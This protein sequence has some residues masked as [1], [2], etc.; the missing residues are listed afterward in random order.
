MVYYN[1]NIVSIDIGKHGAG[2][3]CI[4]PFY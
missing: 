2:R 1:D 3:W 4:Q